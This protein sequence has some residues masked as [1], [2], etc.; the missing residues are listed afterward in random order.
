MY[1]GCEGNAWK[2]VR[3][4]GR[5]SLGLVLSVSSM[6]LV[7]TCTFQH[8]RPKTQGWDAALRASTHPGLLS[9]HGPRGAP[10]TR[11][12]A[13]TAAAPCAAM[14]RLMSVAQLHCDLSGPAV[15]LEHVPRKAGSWREMKAPT[16]RGPCW[17]ALGPRASAGLEQGCLLQSSLARC[18]PHAPGFL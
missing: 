6:F 7:P 11:R 12:K 4:L 17:Q 18:L 16:S 5:V 14:C 8:M 10:W 9:S 3:T 13:T 15:W 1:H 2:N